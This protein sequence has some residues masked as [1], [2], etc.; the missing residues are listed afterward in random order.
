MQNQDA[1]V[2]VGCSL[3]SLLEV[4]FFTVISRHKEDYCF[5]QL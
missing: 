3:G 2:V 5:G 4:F 1:I